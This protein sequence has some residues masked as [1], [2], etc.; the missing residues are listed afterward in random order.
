MKSTIVTTILTGL[1]LAAFVRSSHANSFTL[2]VGHWPP[3]VDQLA[4]QQGGL[5]EIVKQAFNRVGVTISIDFRP[6]T[7]VADEVDRHQRASFGWIWTSKRAQKWLF[8]DEILKGTAVFVIRKDQPFSWQVFDDLK[9]YRIGVTQGYS[10]GE[11]FDRFKTLLRIY[12]SH[13]DEINLRNLLKQRIDLFAVDPIVGA[14]I[15]R[16]TFSS[17]ERQKLRLLLEPPISSYGVYLVCSQS[18]QG[19]AETINRFN[20]GLALL[21]AD[22]TKKQLVEHMLS[23]K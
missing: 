15:L 19:C 17:D 14:H 12:P 1:I 18:A 7:R 23:F 5:T 9:P 11:M 8:S 4:D 2:S 13:S 20:N 6:W 16:T 22:G 10:Y 3:Y 21:N